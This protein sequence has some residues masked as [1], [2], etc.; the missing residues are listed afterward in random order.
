MAATPSITGI[1]P[2]ISEAWLTVVRASP[3]NWM[4]QLMGI[5]NAAESSSVR[6]SAPEKRQ[7]ETS[8]TGSTPR[9]AKRMR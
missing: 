7:R 6:S 1:A 9:Q 8:A 3:L 4:R 2:T 5:P